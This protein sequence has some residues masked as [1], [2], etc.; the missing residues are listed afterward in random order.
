M[1]KMEVQRPPSRVL[2]PLPNG[3]PGMARP[4]RDV[5]EVGK[6][7]CSF[8]GDPKTGKTRLAATF[9]KPILFLATDPE[10]QDSIP[11]TPGVDYVDVNKTEDM[12]LA[13]ELL[14]NGRSWW[15][16]KGEDWER[17]NGPV[18]EPYAT[19]VLDHASKLR[20]VTLMEIM[21]VEE[22]PLKKPWGGKAMQT[23]WMP[24]AA[25]MQNA[26]RPLIRLVKQDKTRNVVVL[27]QEADL[28]HNEEGTTNPLP[29][30]IGAALGKGIADWLDAECSYIGQ[31]LVRQRTRIIPATKNMPEREV[32]DKGVDYCLRVC[33]GDLCRAGFRVPVG[34]DI[35]NE[36]LINPT[37][38]AILAIIQGR[39]LE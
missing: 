24:L 6:L 32:R 11:G 26:F 23:V 7:L 12:V 25:A 9:P 2:Q 18:G 34:V 15:R 3:A 37:Y 17:L 19:G 4:V 10:G 29:P 20:N 33:P 36:F 35:T 21:N 31:T 14:K 16:R 22:M 5:G 28:T 13:T 1:P 27:S 39:P 8:Y 38:D 30:D